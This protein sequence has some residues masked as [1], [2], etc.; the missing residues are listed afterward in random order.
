[1]ET[2]SSSVCLSCGNQCSG[3]FQ[4]CRYQFL[5]L[6]PLCGYVPRCAHLAMKTKLYRAHLPMQHKLSGAHIP[7]RNQAPH[8]HTSLAES[9]PS[10][11]CLPVE[12]R[13]S[14][15][16]LPYKSQAPNVHLPCG[17]QALSAHLPSWKLNPLLQAFPVFIPLSLSSQWN[18]PKEHGDPQIIKP[19][20]ISSNSLASCFSKDLN[21]S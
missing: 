1:M 10:S 11:V 5:Q 4:P 19:E 3:A 9:T 7:G 18:F 6:M 15:V 16:C 2:Q 14:S 12:K 8:T 17:C 13:N 21:T 20:N